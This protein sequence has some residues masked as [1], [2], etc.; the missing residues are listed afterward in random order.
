ME[1]K[2]KWRLGM[3]HSKYLIVDIISYG[4][5]SVKE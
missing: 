2:I 4:S 5:E 1:R 3:L